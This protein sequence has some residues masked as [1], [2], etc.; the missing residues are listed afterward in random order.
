MAVKCSIEEARRFARNMRKQM[1]RRKYKAQL[2]TNREISSD[3]HHEYMMKVIE[4]FGG[5]KKM[6]YRAV[7]DLDESGKI[8]DIVP[9]TKKWIK[10]RRIKQA[11]QEQQLFNLIKKAI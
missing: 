1:T 8:G 2:N 11:E 9:I 7:D 3:L 5:L 4:Y 6:G 10:E